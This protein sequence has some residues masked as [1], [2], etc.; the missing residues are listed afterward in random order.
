MDCTVEKTLDYLAKKW[1]LLIILEIYKGDKYTRRYSEIKANLGKITPKILSAR[2]KELE[3]HE[4]IT[5]TIDA[6]HFPIKCSYSL[7]SSGKDII[8]I[9]KDI[10]KWAL[11][12]NKKNPVCQATNCKNCTF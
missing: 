9:I 12:W 7:T 3:Q 1:S 2:L 8:K 4:L 5:K 10:K 6:T 11:K